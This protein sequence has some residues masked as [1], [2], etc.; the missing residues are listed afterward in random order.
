MC[1]TWHSNSC[2]I[3]VYKS[4]M[5]RQRWLY[6]T[7]IGDK[8]LKLHYILMHCLGSWWTKQSGLVCGWIFCSTW[9]YEKSFWVLWRGMV[10]I[11]FI[12]QKLNTNSSTKSDCSA[13]H[14]SNNLVDIIFF[15]RIGI[16]NHTCHLTSRQ[17]EFHAHQEQQ[18]GIKWQ[19]NKTHEC[20]ILLHHRL[21]EKKRGTDLLL[22]YRWYDRWFFAKPFTRAKFHCFSNIIMWPFTMINMV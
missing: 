12:K 14:T 2:I 9:Q 3:P 6:K 11:N 22:S 17:H 19:R 10:N 1:Q 15:V 8:I 21:S 13:L 18:M 4:N 7:I 5:P 16:S 20:T